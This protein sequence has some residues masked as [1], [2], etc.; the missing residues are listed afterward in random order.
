MFKRPTVFLRLVFI[1]LA[2]AAVM[3]HSA[4]DGDTLAVLSV[5]DGDSLRLRRADGQGMVVRL[6][7]V[8]CPELGQPYGEAARDLT[9]RLVGRRVTVLPSGGKS[10]RR[11]VAVVLLHDG[12]S[13][14]SA[15]V[16]AGMAWVDDR[17]CRRAECDG[18]RKAQAR[19]RA[20]RR[21]L[22]ADADPVPPWQW[23]RANKRPDR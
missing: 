14:Q 16:E 9:R 17:F 12:R 13:L 8:D 23:R 21:G 19:A 3:L 15:L 18:W 1:A 22:W 4:H 7:G 6:Y 20:A 10:W 2:A 11:E 5:H